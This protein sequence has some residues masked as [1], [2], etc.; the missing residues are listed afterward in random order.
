MEKDQNVR[1]LLEYDGS[2]FGGWQRVGNGKKPSIQGTLEQVLEKELGKSGIR[3]IGS[4]RTDA[5]VHALGQVANVHLPYSVWCKKTPGEWRTYW[6][7]CLPEGLRI[8]LA[9]EADRAFHSRYDAVRK[10][11]CYVF[12]VREVPSVFAGKYAYWIGN[13]AFAG[14]GMSGMREWDREA[15][16]QASVWLTGEHDFSAFSSRMEPGRKT[17]RTI[18]RIEW[19]DWRQVGGEFLIFEVEGNGFLYHMVRILA[20]TLY[21][22]GTRSRKPE[23]ILEA[24]RSG[25]RQDAG[26]TLPGYGLFLKEVGYY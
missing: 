26:V 12:D 6:N 25:R 19:K 4:G 18:T 14:T 16:Q 8:R 2:C 22:I 21:E 20:G 5:G 15:V 9:E 24:F 7:G 17:V 13:R 3:V 10:T 23:C 11:Y 1:L